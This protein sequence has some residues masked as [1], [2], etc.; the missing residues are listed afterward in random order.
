MEVYNVEL[1]SHKT[2]VLSKSEKRLRQKN[3]RK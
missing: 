1:L 3:N 2:F